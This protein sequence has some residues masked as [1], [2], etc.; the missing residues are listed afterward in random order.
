MMPM[1]EGL[2]PARVK[3]ALSELMPPIAE[4]RVAV[5]VKDIGAV[6]GKLGPGFAVT[7]MGMVTVFWFC[8]M[9]TVAGTF[10]IEPTPVA[11]VRTRVTLVGAMAG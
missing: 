9:V 10:T 2:E 4:V 1:M 3:V 8:A 6:A 7:L 5:R 11:P